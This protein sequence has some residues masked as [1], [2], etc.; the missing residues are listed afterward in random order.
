MRY[1]VTVIESFLKTFAEL[2]C[3]WLFKDSPKSSAIV[4]FTSESGEVLSLMD[5]DDSRNACCVDFLES[6]GC[7]IFYDI[8][9]MNAYIKQTSGSMDRL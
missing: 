7:R 4:F 3:F 5:D 8:S 2:D 6:R 1:N 9:E